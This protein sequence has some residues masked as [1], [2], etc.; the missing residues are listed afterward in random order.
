MTGI[1]AMLEKAGPQAQIVGVPPL[2]DNVYA[3][4]DIA[5]YRGWLR[6]DADM[7]KRFN[8]RF[9]EGG[10]LTGGEQVQCVARA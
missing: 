8:A 4:G 1:S 7:Q 6:A 5:D 3:V 10:I 2:F 9:R